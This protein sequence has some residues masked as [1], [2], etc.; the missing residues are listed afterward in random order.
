MRPVVAFKVAVGEERV[1]CT[2]GSDEAGI[3]RVVKSQGVVAC[4]PSLENT[5]D[6]I[7]GA[8]YEGWCIIVG[9]VATPQ[10][11]TVGGILTAGISGLKIEGLSVGVAVVTIAD[12]RSIY[13]IIIDASLRGSVIE[14]NISCSLPYS[15]S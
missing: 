1:R 14:Q 3:V 4:A 6:G 5:P 11:I 12:E 7:A 15:L 2:A 8:A 10:E 9:T 13:K